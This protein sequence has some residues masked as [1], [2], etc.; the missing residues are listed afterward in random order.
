MNLQA[1]LFINCRN[2][3]ISRLL[4]KHH[5]VN[6][7]TKLIDDIYC[8]RSSNYCVYVCMRD[9]FSI[10]SCSILE[11]NQFYSFYIQFLLVFAV[12]ALVLQDTSVR[13]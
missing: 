6:P 7:S 9:P 13:I 5:F 4:I 11:Y 2:I 8:N 12:V 1:I 10:Q 3:F